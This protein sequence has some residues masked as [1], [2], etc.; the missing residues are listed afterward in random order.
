MSAG[1]VFQELAWTLWNTQFHLGM[2]VFPIFFACFFALVLREAVCDSVAIENP[3]RRDEI[4]K[5]LEGGE[6]A[7]KKRMQ[8]LRIA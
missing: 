8:K 7:L 2:L 3:Q 1:Y 6:I 4:I 5:I